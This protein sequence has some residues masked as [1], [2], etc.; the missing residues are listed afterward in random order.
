[1]NCSLVGSDV[2][3]LPTPL[4]MVDLNILEQNLDTLADISKAAGVVCRPHSKSHK[5]PFI[6]RKQMDRGAVGICCVKVSEAE[7]MV[8]SGIT[9]I[10]I[11]SPVVNA[12]MIGRMVALSRHAEISVVTDTVDNVRAIAEACR[13]WDCTLNIVIEVEV[14]QRRCGVKDATTALRILEEVDSSPH[15][16]FAGL[17]GYQG[18]LQLEPDFVKR[19]EGVKKA[20]GELQNVV[21]ALTER[22]ISIPV[23]TGGGTGTMPIDVDLGVLTELQ[24]GSYPFMDTR[25]CNIGWDE[26][27]AKPPFQSSLSVLGTVLSRPSSTEA[28]LDTG[29]K[30]LSLDGGTPT[31]A[32]L[33]GASFQFAGDEHGVIAFEGQTPLNVGDV[34]KIFP[35]HCDTTLNLYDHAV[36]VRNGI[37][38][39]SWRIETRGKTQ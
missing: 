29:W 14:G 28:I 1:M 22:K 10:A 24:P 19:R 38:E 26:S 17:Q 33:D 11:T 3:D 36:G 35:S 8:Q 15:L 13:V 30:A 5:S 31:P 12:T 27:G 32:D 9:D 39:I 37:V 16:E 4:L 18:K 34:V 21:A 23:L 20:Y 6:A 7:V 2:Y 25:Y